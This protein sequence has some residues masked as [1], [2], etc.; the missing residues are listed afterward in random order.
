[1]TQEELREAKVVIRLMGQF[2]VTVDGKRVEQTISRSYKG[3]LLMQILLVHDGETVPS[4]RLYQALWPDD[5]KHQNPEN[6]LKTLVS[7]LRG[8]LSRI[9]PLLEKC[10][11]TERGG[12]RW[13][14]EPQVYV[15]VVELAEV[16]ARL[17]E[18]STE[19]GLERALFKRLTTLYTGELLQGK[20]DVP[21]LHSRSA[22]FHRR[23]INEMNRCLSALSERGNHEL[24][25]DVCKRIIQVEKLNEQ[26][27]I[28]LMKAM[29]RLGRINEAIDHYRYVER[30][31][32][33][34][35][36]ITPSEEMKA[37]Y[38][39]ISSPG[40]RRLPGLASIRQELDEINAAP[41][42]YMCDQVVFKAGY[43]I[44]MRNS[45][46]M[47]C[48]VC[49]ASVAVMSNSGEP[50][51]ADELDRATEGL[52][53]VM[54]TIFRPGDMVSRYAMN[55]VLVMMPVTTRAV[56]SDLLDKVCVAF[57]R[58]FPNA[59]WV[60]SVDLDEMSGGYGGTESPMVKFASK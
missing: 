50:L 4:N 30:L 7:R 42:T 25:M 46:R 5:E 53:E 24:V 3:V 48:A 36:G 1:M 9:S 13:Q 47:L 8:H 26:V 16:L 27:Y 40:V 55:I 44:L 32:F 54:R 15:D 23:Y 38:R 11:V 37:F 20:A 60:L 18:V 12:Y 52:G 45:Q 56:A 31:F 43:N 59:G 33:R 29:V 58:K 34:Y 6:A 2:S 39:S 21:L 14:S 10:I 28:E 19:E 22:Y 57:Y 41:G 35:L 49:L 51:S 17:S